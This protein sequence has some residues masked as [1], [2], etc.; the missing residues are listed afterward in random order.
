MTSALFSILRIR[1]R[2]LWTY[3]SAAFAGVLTQF[4]W[5]FLRM[6][7][8]RAFVA[9]RPEASP[10]SVPIL[11]GYVWL[12]QAFFAIY[13]WRLDPEIPLCFREGRVAHELLRPLAVFPHWWARHLG[14]LLGRAGLRCGPILVTSLALGWLTPS[15]DPWQLGL[16]FLSLVL[17]WMLSATI[18]TTLSTML[19]WT[20]ASEGLVAM[21]TAFF[22]LASGQTVPLPL[23]PEGLVA[24]LRLLPYRGV[25]DTPFR[26]LLGDLRGWD[27]VL[28]L[29]HQLGWILG[30]CV[31]APRLLDRFLH[32]L[33]IHGG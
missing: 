17:A 18:L 3:R 9:T 2:G 1:V 31:L 22:F 21:N 15:P 8:F 7:I 10:V 24:W 27:L 12:G 14:F 4:F 6:V 28:G 26:I 29:G 19:F 11:D 16:G 30:L 23:L 32:R 13:P 5:G 25:V 33:E 20:H